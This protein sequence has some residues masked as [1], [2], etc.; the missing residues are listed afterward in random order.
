MYVAARDIPHEMVKIVKKKV[1]L[2]L[3]GDFSL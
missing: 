3:F 1:M 2:S